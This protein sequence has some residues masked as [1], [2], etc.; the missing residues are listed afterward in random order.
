VT[1]CV[2]VAGENAYLADHLGLQIFDIAD[3]Y[4]VSRVTHFSSNGCGWVETDG[5]YAYLTNNSGVQVIDIRDPEN[6]VLV[7]YYNTPGACGLAVDMDILY[8][9]NWDEGVK[10]LRFTGHEGGWPDPPS[11]PTGPSEGETHV[12][13][14]FSTNTTD[15]ESDEV[16]YGWD[17]NSDY[18]VDEWT[19]YY[20]SGDLVETMHNWSEADEYQIRVKAK[21]TGEH[22]SDWSDPLT[23]MIFPASEP[24]LVID[25]ITGGL[26]LSVAI[27]NVGTANATDVDMEMVIENGLFVFPRKLGEHIVDEFPPDE[28]HNNSVALFGIGL[29]IVTEI[30]TILVRVNASN[31]D[32][33]E[34]SVIAKI[35]GPFVLIQ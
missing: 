23:I 28:T 1:T 24:E 30:P 14:L 6:P 19:T 31:A 16:S 15:P 20:P 17:W 12:D 11:T 8:V 3:P 13:Y 5:T 26:G 25:S 34:E 2:A 7:G 29:G 32:M 9:A 22:I 27:R 33:I 4:D 21:D 18:V 35:F 10:V